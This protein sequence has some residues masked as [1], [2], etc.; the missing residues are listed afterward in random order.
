MAVLGA[1]MLADDK[2]TNEAFGTIELRT[3][4]ERSIL[5]SISRAASD[6]LTRCL[7]W[8][9]EWVGAPADASLVLNTDFG[10]ARMQP[11]MVTAL[12]QAYQNDAM[13]LSVLFENYQRGELINP[14]MEYEEYE[15]QLAE[16]GPS[17]DQQM[18]SQ[19]NSSSNDQAQGQDQGLIDNI[20]RRLG[21]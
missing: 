9:A 6:S 3:A 11:Q 7:N 17:F 20:R 16:Q 15:A 18:P 5:A 2:R 13:P 4:G 8:M 21:L 14:E 10:A 1:R 12:L 19:D